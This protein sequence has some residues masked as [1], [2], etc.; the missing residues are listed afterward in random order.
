MIRR[1]GVAVML[2]VL[3]GTGWA[4]AG[5]I[6]ALLERAAKEADQGKAF[7]AAATL[8]QALMEV[9]ALKPLSIKGAV[10]VQEEASGYGQYTPRQG[11]VYKGGEPILIYAEP[12][13]YR[14][15]RQGENY[16]FGFSADF[17][18]LSEE[19]KVLAGQRDFNKWEFRSR[20]PMFEV[21]VNLTYNLTG[22]PPG[23]YLIET[24]FN[25]SFSDGKVSFKLPIVIK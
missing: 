20:E 13:G 25:D 21:Y 11:N 1:I 3:L 8:R 17:A 15:K 9:W 5:D 22:A 4:M 6:K 24:T 12:V 7:E 18:I 23:K 10:L 14:F 2:I 16:L 19:G